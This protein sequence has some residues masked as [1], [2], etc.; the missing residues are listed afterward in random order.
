[1]FL[2]PFN[3]RSN[4]AI[5]FKVAIVS[6]LG[7]AALS[8]AEKAR[9]GAGDLFATDAVNNSVVV[10]ALDGTMRTFASGLNNPQGLAFDQFGNLFVADKGSG[11]IYKYTADATRSTFAT[12]VSDPVGLTFSGMALAVAEQSDETMRH[13]RVSPF[14]C[15][16][17]TSLILLR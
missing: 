3:L 11:N 17:S 7:A 6:S 15:L 8:L 12:G 4:L 2:F 1:M 13:R 16:T 10:Y 9:A 5:S 14:N